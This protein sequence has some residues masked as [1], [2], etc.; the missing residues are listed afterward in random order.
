MSTWI[1]NG[2]RNDGQEY[3]DGGGSHEPWENQ[4]SHCE[5]CGLPK[6]VGVENNNSDQVSSIEDFSKSHRTKTS[7]SKIKDRTISFPVIGLTLI[8]A[9]LSLG[10][11]ATKFLISGG[12]SQAQDPQKA[13]TSQPILNPDTNTATPVNQSTL[14]SPIATLISYQNSKYGM[15]INYPDNWE[16]QEK[17]MI[18]TGEIVTFFSPSNNSYGQFREQVILS[19]IDLTHHPHFLSLNEYSQV[20]IK[21]IAQEAKSNS[22]KTTSANLSHRQAQSITYETNLEGYDVQVKKIW[23]LYNNQAYVITYISDQQSESQWSP[24]VDKMIKSFQIQ[25]Q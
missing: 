22:T 6:T 4:G 10:F 1:C 23:T 15:T 13:K 3:L 2:I 11:V 9:C 12:L 7:Q 16:R 24:T 20:V 25:Q 8:V 18:T 17:Y 21:E 19:V 5:F 14:P